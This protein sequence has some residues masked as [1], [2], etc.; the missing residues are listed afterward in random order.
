MCA[1][2]VLVDSQFSLLMFPK[3]LESAQQSQTNEQLE[4]LCTECNTLHAVTVKAVAEH[5]AS[6]RA[7]LKL[8]MESLT[9]TAVTATE[10]ALRER[11]TMVEAE[12]DRLQKE[13]DILKKMNVK[14]SQWLDDQELA[15]Q[16]KAEAT[17]TSA[18]LGPLSFPTLSGMESGLTTQVSLQLR[19][20]MSG[21]HERHPFLRR[22]EAPQHTSLDL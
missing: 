17:A 15:A 5:D 21:R 4:A 1:L 3:T 13:N 10:T 6:R 22:G 18:A 16:V 9:N 14:Q 12:V 11:C 19:G 7:H 20:G 2:L 8:R